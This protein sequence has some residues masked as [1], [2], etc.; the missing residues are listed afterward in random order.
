MYMLD[1]VTII[2]APVLLG[3]GK[4][5]LSYILGLCSPYLENFRSDDIV[6]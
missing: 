2:V 1:P 6:K 5:L 3:L 4:S